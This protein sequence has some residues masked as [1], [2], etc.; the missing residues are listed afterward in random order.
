MGPGTL[1]SHTLKD[2]LTVENPSVEHSG[3]P[4][5]KLDAN[6]RNAGVASGQQ[7]PT[8]GPS[9]GRTPEVVTA[10]RTPKNLSAASTGC[11]SSWASSAASSGSSL[12]ELDT[13]STLD[14][15]ASSWSTPWGPCF[16]LEARAVKGTC[17]CTHS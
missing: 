4:V 17:K 16:Q 8:F 14:C 12:F 10:G 5:Y 15:P 6:N 3:S 9:C 13:C 7:C 11:V 1:A 2:Q